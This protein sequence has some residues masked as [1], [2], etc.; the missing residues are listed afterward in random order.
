VTSEHEMN[1]RAIE[2]IDFG[3][4]LVVVSALLVEI[5]FFV[6]VVSILFVNVEKTSAS[7]VAGSNVFPLSKGILLF[8]L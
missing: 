3:V 6:V 7:N 8:W 5:T 2:V 1:M 4:T